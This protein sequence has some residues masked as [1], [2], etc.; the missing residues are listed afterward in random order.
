[1]TF[2]TDIRV[3]YSEL[4][5]PDILGRVDGEGPGQDQQADERRPSRAHSIGRRCVLL[6]P[7]SSQLCPCPDRKAAASTG[8]SW[9]WRSDDSVMSVA[10]S[11]GANAAM[12]WRNCSTRVSSAIPSGGAAATI[13]S[14]TFAPAAGPPGP[15][16]SR[17]AG[18]PAVVAPATTAAVAAAVAVAPAATIATAAAIGPAPT[19]PTAAA[20]APTAVPS[21]PSSAHP[22]RAR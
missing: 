8:V 4:L 3:I 1:G 14:S 12:A 16:V 11:D 21:T 5:V 18:T 15:P 7:G 20:P 9:C 2:R 13:G 10:D 22:A 6:R 17:F 19:I